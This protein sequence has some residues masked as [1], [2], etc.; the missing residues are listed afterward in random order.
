MERPQRSFRP[1]FHFPSKALPLLSPSPCSQARGWV[2]PPL[3]LPLE[4][5]RH[6]LLDLIGDLALCARGGNA[7]IPN[8]HIVAYKVRARPSFSSRLKNRL[9]LEPCRHKLLDLIGDLALCAR[10]GNA[11]ISNAHI[12]AYKASHALHVAF[13]KALMGALEA[14]AKGHGGAV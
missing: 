12:V 6:K 10:G 5:C 11:G 8:A 3:R 13:G 2:N 1:H 4:P 7:G 9:P 14:E